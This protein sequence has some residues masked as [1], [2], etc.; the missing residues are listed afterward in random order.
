MAYWDWGDN[1]RADAAPFT[2][3]AWSCRTDLYSA[4]VSVEATTSTN[5]TTLSFDEAEYTASK[6]LMEG[7]LINQTRLE[8][9]FLARNW[10]SMIYTASPSTQSAFGGP[11]VLLAGLYN[12]DPISMMNS[13][14][15]LN[16]TQRLLQRFFGEAVLANIG[17]SPTASRSGNVVNTQRR[18]VVNLPIAIPLAVLFLTSAVL[19]AAVLLLSRQHPLDLTQDPSSVAAVL[20]VIEHDPQIRDRFRA[21]NRDKGQTP[22]RAL[23]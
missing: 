1:S 2:G 22:E 10:T 14:S 7:G 11:S 4:D 21:W 20:R 8:T 16:N 18:V 17:S 6:R 15:L 5:G 9:A 12:F 19:I 13:P 23:G 3:R